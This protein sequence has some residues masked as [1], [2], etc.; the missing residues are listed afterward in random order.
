MNDP[1][2]TGVA[3]GSTGFGGID[4][5]FS[6]GGNIFGGIE[7]QPHNVVHV[8]VGGSKDNL[9]REPG[10]MTVPDS[11]ALD[12]IFWLH[13]ANIDRLWAAWNGMTPSHLDPGESNWVSGPASV[14]D[15]SFAQPR[16][17]GTAWTYTPGEMT[18]IQTLGY[19][20]DDLTPGVAP[21][22]HRRRLERLG[23]V[24]P[25]A[26]AAAIPVAPAPI[27]AA[28]AAAAAAAPAPIAAAT[29]APMALWAEEE[30]AVPSNT[31]VELVGASTRSV[32]VRGA[33]ARSHVRLDSSMRRK[34]TASL[35]APPVSAAGIAEAAAPDRVFLNLENVRGPSD[36]VIFQVYVGVPEGEDPAER[37]DLL[38][39]TIAPFGLSK[40]SR[41]DD[42]H[43]GQG[44]T[45]VLEITDLVDG[46][47]LSNSFDVDRLPVRIVPVHPVPDEAAITI[48]RISIYR[49]GR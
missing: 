42:E 28:A 39:G 49:Q 10:A 30:T 36:S 12:P 48:G 18:D 31:N 22:H 3:G 13:H 38:A 29:A 40:A 21:G 45:F 47:H 34:V 8:L 11:A 16:P 37:P 17:D 35:S 26:A 14:G 27:A 1:D 25:Q 23:L 9:H 41:P 33:D 5:G 4:T 2:F 6:H 19:Q 15:R 7:S 46:L 44:L 20:Y 43:A 24:E 32:S